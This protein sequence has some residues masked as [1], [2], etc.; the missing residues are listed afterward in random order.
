M[1]CHWIK[2]TFGDHMNSHCLI[3]QSSFLSVLVLFFTKVSSCNY[4]KNLR[5]MI[6]MRT[7]RLIFASYILTQRLGTYKS[8][9]STKKVKYFLYFYT[10][11]V[12]FYLFFQ[13]SNKI[14]FLFYQNKANIE[15]FS[16]TMKISLS[17]S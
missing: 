1:V 3:H 11:K 6:K 2:I 8:S 9:L 5:K 17:M 15:L 4:N 7:T 14:L 13:K 16:P 12:R 10:I